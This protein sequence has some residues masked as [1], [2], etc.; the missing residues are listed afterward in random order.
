MAKIFHQPENINQLSPVG[1]KFVIENLPN[2]SWFITAVSLPGVS[3][4]AAPF[5]TPFLQTT[6]PG[7]TM[8]FEDLNIT[9]I[10]DEDMSTWLEIFDW[11][12]GLGFPE[13]Y[14]QYASQKAKFLTSDATLIILNSDMRPNFHFKFRDLFPVGLSEIAFDSSSTEITTLKAAVSFKYLSYTYEKV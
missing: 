13:E 7:E 1:Y 4:G 8:T 11:I 3:L 9:F 10:I 5:P 14:P 6:V 2:T 12:A